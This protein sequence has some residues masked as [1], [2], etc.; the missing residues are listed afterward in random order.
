MLATACHRL[1]ERKDFQHF[2]L[3]VIVFT[4]IV[5][6]LETDASLKAAYGP[7]LHTLNTVIQGI[8]VF[9]IVVRLVAHWPRLGRFF[10]DGWNVA[11]FLIVTASLLP[12][13][14]AF[15]T[16][17]RLARLLRVARLL[18]ASPELRLI[19]S[20]MLRSIP[21]LGNVTLLLSLVLYIYAITGHHFFH[22]NDPEHWG[23]L[24]RSLMT[25][26]QILTLEGWIEV[27]KIS[28]EVYPYAWMFFSSYVVIAV[29]VVI[30]LFIAVVLNNM[31]TAREEHEMEENKR[32][33]RHDLLAR[34]HTLK[35]ELD[36]LERKL[37]EDKT[38]E[39]K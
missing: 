1:A 15:A 18:S 11:D 6:G 32:H 34:I 13:V 24:G 27:Q 20:T 31:E 35:Q 30:N 7:V 8:F 29:F 33:P 25:L 16:V 39:T 4:A 21:S 19:I 17:A 37:R 14:G 12:Q 38:G 3:G 22:E 2:I 10:R 26:F 28:L 9:E 36:D 23:T 5:M